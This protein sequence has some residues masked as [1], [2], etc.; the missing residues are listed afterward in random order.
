VVLLPLV[1]G[2]VGVGAWQAW[3]QLSSSEARA[4]G[5]LQFSV[6]R[7]RWTDGGLALETTLELSRDAAYQ[8][9]AIYLE[10]RSGTSGAR[11]DEMQWPDGAPPTRRGRHHLRLVWRSLATEPRAVNRRLVFGVRASSDRTGSS[12]PV[13]E[14]QVP[15]DEILGAPK[16]SGAADR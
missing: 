1:L 14:F 16:R 11:V 2:A 6:E 8:Y 10:D 13:A 12:P 7:G 15:L 3:Q 9:H 4:R 5:T